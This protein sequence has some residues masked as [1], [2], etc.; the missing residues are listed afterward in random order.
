MSENLRTLTAATYSLAFF[1]LL[2]CLFG[3]IA[4]L[5]ILGM[6]RSGLNAAIILLQHLFSDIMVHIPSV[7]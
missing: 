6:I 2:A 1:L 3:G 7:V 5:D 4:G